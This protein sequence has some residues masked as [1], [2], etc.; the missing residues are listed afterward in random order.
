[1][2]QRVNGSLAVSRA[3]G[4]FEYKQVEGKGPCEQ[5][6]SPEPEITVQERDGEK[7]EFLVL[8]CDGIWDVLNNNELCDYIRYM[9]TVEEDVE[10]ICSSIIDICLHKGSKDN[11][12][13]VLVVFGGAPKPSPEAKLKDSQL[14]QLLET[15]VKDILSWNEVLSIS[16][17]IQKLLSDG[18]DGL[19][20]GAGIE[21]KRNLIESMYVKIKGPNSKDNEKELTDY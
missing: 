2:I 7:D 13:V 15:K 3:L 11:M 12:S 5:L 18:I 9:L 10:Q 20:P 8:A 16:G 1:M 6:V 17:V 4:D 19:P 14:D 21:A